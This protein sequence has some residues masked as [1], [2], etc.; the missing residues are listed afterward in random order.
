MSELLS[1]EAEQPGRIEPKRR[2]ARVGRW[3]RRHWVVIILFVIAIL[4]LSEYL[5]LP[6]SDEIARLRRKNPGSTA[7]MEQRK[8]EARRSRKP[9]QIQWQWV[10]L[11]QMSDHV[12]RAVVVAEDGTFY[13]HDGIDWYEVKESIWKDIT[14]RSFARGASTI[15]QQLAKNLYLTT[16]KDPLRKLREIWIAMAMESELSKHRILELYLNVIEFGNGVFG[17]EA[18]ALRYFG[19][20]AS[21]LSR[22]E[23]ARLAAIIP[24][25]LRH[26]PTDESRFVQYRMSLIQTRMAARGW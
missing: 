16:S 24:S 5:S 7:L 26:M 11:S 1:P 6:G 8:A 20:S 19:K 22:D 13:E 23:A 2:I 10:P 18:A 4:L 12:L 14:K 3:C 21:E 9:Y 17:V 15:T 25:P